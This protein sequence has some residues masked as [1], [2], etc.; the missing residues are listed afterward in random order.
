LFWSAFRRIARQLWKRAW[1]WEEAEAAAA[2]G[3]WDMTTIE[4]PMSGNEVR[5]YTALWPAS[6]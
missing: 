1:K 6:Q 4:E 5:W 3:V 2:A